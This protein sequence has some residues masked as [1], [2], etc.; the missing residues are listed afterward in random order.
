VHGSM[1]GPYQEMEGAVIA[2]EILEQ[3]GAPTALTERVVFIV[4]HHHT[5]SKIDGPDF[6]ILW[7]ADQ[8]DNLEFGEKMEVEEMRSAIAERFKTRTG[9]ALAIQRLMGGKGRS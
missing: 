9:K 6:Q 3:G 5:P 2:R 7:E 4:G 8:L 1:D